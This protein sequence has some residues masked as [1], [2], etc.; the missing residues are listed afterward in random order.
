MLQLG[1]CCSSELLQS[2]CFT[3]CDKKIPI[4]TNSYDNDIMV[5]GIHAILGLKKGGGGGGGDFLEK[6]KKKK[7]L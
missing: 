1:E 6:F 2:S 3:I 7:N 5:L 4:T